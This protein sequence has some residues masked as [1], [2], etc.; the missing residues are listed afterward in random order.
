MRLDTTWLL[1]Y[2]LFVSFSF[3]L[4]RSSDGSVTCPA[5]FGSDEMVVIEASRI[6][7]GYC[8]CPTTGEDEPNTQACS[9]RESWSGV[10]K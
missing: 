4:V 9:G 7:D 10:H 2:A 6:N 8:D 3:C 5:G 1:N